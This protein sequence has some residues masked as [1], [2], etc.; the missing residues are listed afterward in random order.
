MGMRIFFAAVGVVA[1]VQVFVCMLNFVK[2][3]A[4]DDLTVG[5]AEEGKQGCRNHCSFHFHFFI[6]LRIRKLPIDI[7]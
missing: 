2:R 4:V 3:I 7:R 5:G 6:I 1:G